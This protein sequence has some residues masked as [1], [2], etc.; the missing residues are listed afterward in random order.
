MPVKNKTK[1]TSL[2]CRSLRPG[3]HF[4]TRCKEDTAKGAQA[5]CDMTWDIVSPEL[6]IAHLAAFIIFAVTCLIQILGRLEVLPALAGRAFRTLHT[7]EL[8]VKGH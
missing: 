2:L 4:G 5:S 7:S 1:G 3:H 8:N 6:K